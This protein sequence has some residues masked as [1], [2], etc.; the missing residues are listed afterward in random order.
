M[1]WAVGAGQPEKRKSRFLVPM[2]PIGTRNDGAGFGMTRG[3]SCFS[4]RPARDACYTLRVKT[5]YVYI[6]ASRSRT[7]YTGVTN[8][9]ERRG[10]RR[11]LIL[12]ICDLAQRMFHDHPHAVPFGNS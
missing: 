3:G 9:L 11:S 2:N 4:A 7:L 8:N 5:S 1:T 10:W 6:M 12:A